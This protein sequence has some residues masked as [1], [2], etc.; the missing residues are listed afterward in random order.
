[1]A[2]YVFN[3]AKGRVG[4]LATRVKNGDPGTSRLFL[5]ALKTD[6]TQAT[7][8]D[9]DDFAAFVTAGGAE[10]DNS[11]YAKKTLAAADIVTPAPD[12]AG[13]KFVVD[14][15]DQTWTAILAGNA[16]VALLVCYSSVTAPT[17][18]QMTVMTHHDFAVTPD[19]SDITAQIA[20]A[21]IFNAS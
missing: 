2:N 12:D 15:N 19:G 6:V 3:I 18:G 7:A 16:W 13:D 9:V 5:V 20:T 8:I 14:I 1:M 4:E 17:N 10:S 11:G 21:G